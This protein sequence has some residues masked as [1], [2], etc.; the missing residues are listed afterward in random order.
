MGISCLVNSFLKIQD[1]CDYYCSFCTIPFARG[2]SRNGTI[3]ETV[4]KAEEIAGAGI[5]EVVLTGVNIGDFGQQGDESFF[6]LIR[7]LE[8]VEGIERFRISSIE[9]NL[10]ND[11]IIEFI[12]GSRKFLPHLHIP[13]QSGSDHILHLMRRKYDTSLF[14]KRIRKIREHMP[15]A[16]IGLDVIVGFPGESDE[17]FETSYNFLKDLDV[18]YLHVFSYSERKNT[19]SAKMDQKVTPQIIEERSNRLHLL[20]ERKRIE[21]ACKNTESEH[22][23]LFEGNVDMESQKDLKTGDSLIS[24]WTANY[25]K[26]ICDSS[27]IENGEIHRVFASGCSPDGILTGNLKQNTR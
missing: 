20:S 14:S 6:Q 10:I 7:E 18:S 11:E 16:G 1:G 17:E 27:G 19:R 25:I 13:L 3:S 22:E 8:K 15:L 4:R 21:F 24:G 2:K 12:A 26:F 23:V 9:P 5:K